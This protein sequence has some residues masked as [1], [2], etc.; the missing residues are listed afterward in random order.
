MGG[1][2]ATGFVIGHDLEEFRFGLGAKKRIGLALSTQDV[3]GLIAIIVAG[4]DASIFGERTEKL[5]GSKECRCV[6][7][8]KHRSPCASDEESVAGKKP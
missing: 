1:L 2:P 4:V 6:R 3:A 5:K 7:S 8:R